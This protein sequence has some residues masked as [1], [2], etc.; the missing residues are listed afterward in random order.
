MLT[1][2]QIMTSDVVTI[3]P[4]ATIQDAIELLVHRR[5]S[6]LPVVDPTG[7]LVGIITEFALLAMAYNQDVQ[8]D[9]VE[10]HMTRDVL[11][12]DASDAI[13]HVTDVFIL[14]R[15]RRLPVVQGGRLVGLLS[16]HDVL[17]ALL[18]EQAPVCTA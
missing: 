13:S 5:I 14:H 16:R 7:R 12:V 10:H 9:P 17:S 15:V 4:N 11:T 2:A 6:G 3:A 1:A 8:N 18:S